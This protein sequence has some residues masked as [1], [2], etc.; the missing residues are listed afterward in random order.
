[1]TPGAR[2]PGGSNETTSSVCGV[3]PSMHREMLR[4]TAIRTTSPNSIPRGGDQLP[5]DAVGNPVATGVTR[6][7]VAVVLEINPGE[8]VGNPVTSGVTRSMPVTPYGAGWLADSEVIESE[9]VIV[10]VLVVSTESWLLAPVLTL[11]LSLARSC[12]DL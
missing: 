8:A 6:E 4:E 7:I 1:M 9:D 3:T 2:V 10:E 12:L 5:G 11:A